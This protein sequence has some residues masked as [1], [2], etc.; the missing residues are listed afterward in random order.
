MQRRAAEVMLLSA[1]GNLLKAGVLTPRRQDALPGFHAGNE[2]AEHRLI[3]LGKGDKRG[4]Y[5]R[6]V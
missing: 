3:V 1:S 6:L 5:L 4:E 2:G